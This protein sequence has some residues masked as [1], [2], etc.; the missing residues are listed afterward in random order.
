MRGFEFH[1]SYD[2]IVLI[3]PKYNIFTEGS[4]LGSVELSFAKTDDESISARDSGKNSTIGENSTIGNSSTIGSL[5]RIGA[6]KNRVCVLLWRPFYI[7]V[8]LI[9]SFIVT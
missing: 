9:L 6:R 8:S 3:K 1:W 5:P 2:L 7:Y 4:T